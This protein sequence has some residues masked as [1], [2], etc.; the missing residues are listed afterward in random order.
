MSY[1]DTL[2]HLP[3][4]TVNDLWANQRHKYDYQTRYLRYWNS[5]AG[6]TRSGRPVDAIIAPATPTASHKPSEGMYFGYTGVYNVLDFSAAVIPV[7]KADRTLDA[8][9]ADYNPSGDLDSAIWKQCMYLVI[10]SWV[11]ILANAVIRLY[12]C[13]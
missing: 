13:R 10:R 8:R 1:G 5:T 9:V 3:V 4:G 7:T 11:A 12:R 6:Q 2:G